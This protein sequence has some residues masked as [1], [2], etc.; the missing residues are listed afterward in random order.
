VPKVCL[1]NKL[2]NAY[3]YDNFILLFFNIKR[4]YIKISN[5]KKLSYLKKEKLIKNKETNIIISKKKN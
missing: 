5:K 2:K 1:K 4:L 3:T